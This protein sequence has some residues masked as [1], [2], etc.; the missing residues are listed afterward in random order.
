MKIGD[1]AWEFLVGIFVVAVVFMLARPG[2]PAAQA[3]ADV[4]NA[5]AAMIGTAT[6][7][8]QVSPLTVNSQGQVTN[9]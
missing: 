6:G 2:S 9:G 3:V 5:L 1:I 7:Q 8:A 4:S